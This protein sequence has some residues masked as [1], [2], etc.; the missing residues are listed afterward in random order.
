LFH[1]H[2]LDE[3]NAQK[4]LILRNCTQDFALFTSDLHNTLH[5]SYSSIIYTSLGASI[6]PCSL[7]VWDDAISPYCYDMWDLVTLKYS[8]VTTIPIPSS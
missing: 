5:A 1:Q 6:G 2:E 3:K 8:M 4:E 7:D